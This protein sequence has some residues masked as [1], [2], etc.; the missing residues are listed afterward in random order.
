MIS[1]F[2]D[3]FNIYVKLSHFFYCFVWL[4]CITACFFLLNCYLLVHLLFVVS[5]TPTACETKFLKHDDAF[6]L[7]YFFFGLFLF[8]NLWCTC[9]KRSNFKT[10]LNIY[11]LKV[12]P[13][14]MVIKPACYVICLKKNAPCAAVKF[15]E[16]DKVVMGATR[17]ALINWCAHTSFCP[18]F[19]L[20]K[21]MEHLF[22]LSINRAPLDQYTGTTPCLSRVLYN[23]WRMLYYSATLNPPIWT[24]LIIQLY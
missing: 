13:R 2:S 20:T 8:G 11:S 23:R 6:S 17:Y 16:I 15:K 22:Y 7:V 3:S 24:S 5:P 14:V 12:K 4:F 18:R 21:S 19:A 9:K 10:H 1:G